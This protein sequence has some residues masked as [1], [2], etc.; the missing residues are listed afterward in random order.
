M[1]HLKNSSNPLVKTTSRINIDE[2]TLA[3]GI[4]QR[5]EANAIELLS[6][7]IFFNSNSKIKEIYVT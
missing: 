7:N 2:N 3:I 4:S 1:S 6:R 5:T